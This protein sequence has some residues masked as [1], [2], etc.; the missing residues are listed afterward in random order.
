MYSQDNQEHEGTTEEAIVGFNES[1]CVLMT[2]SLCV[3][4]HLA[5]V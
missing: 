1:D 2:M 4:T 5:Y 3:G